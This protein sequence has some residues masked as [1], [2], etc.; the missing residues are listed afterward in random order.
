MAGIFHRE[1]GFFI[2]DPETA[3]F[4]ADYAADGAARRA[5]LQDFI[6]SA[7][8]WRKIFAADGDGESREA[9]TT[10]GDREL[11]AAAAETFAE[12]LRKRS[13]KPSPVA[14]V[15]LDTRFTGPGI[16][17]VMIRVFLLRGI[18]V[19]YLFIVPAPEIMAW[20]KSSRDIDGFAYVSASHNPVGH[21]GLK[22]GLK[23]GVLGGKDAEELIRDFRLLA[24]DDRRMDGTVRELRQDG[25][26]HSRIREEVRRVYGE[27]GPWKKESGSAYG[28]FVRVVASDLSRPGDRQVFFDRLS[29]EIGRRGC[30]IVID[31]NGGAR[32]LSV[33][34]PLLEGLGVRVRIVNGGARDIAHAIVPEGESLETC[35]RELELARERDPSFVFGY[36]PDNDGDRGNLVFFDEASGRAR[37]LE[38]Q[39]VFALACAA[40]L[41]YLAARRSGDTGAEKI[42]VVVNDPTSLRIDRIAAAL[43]AEVRR[44]EVGE[45]NVVALAAELRRDGYTVRILG[46]GSNG[47]NITHPSEVRDPLSTVFAVLKLLHLPEPY[48]ILCRAVGRPDLA[49][50]E[51][52]IGKILGMLPAFRTLGASDPAAILKIRSGDHMALKARYEEIFLREWDRRRR[53]LES[54]FGITSWEEL[55]HEGTV[56]R[57][58][59]GP[60]SRT[61]NGRGGLT[62]LLKGPSGESRGFL[63]M[64]GSGTEPVFRIL[65][66]L[67]GGDGDLLAELAAWQRSMVLE[68]DREG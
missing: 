47:G 53:D 18:R 30:G 59:T 1:T 5:A 8:G 62:I 4:P 15:G 63:W 50:S 38:A 31:M 34:R 10:P 55:N 12:F 58:G 11:C 32:V 65:A 37:P 68:A 16:A 13:G 29:R 6:L 54:R 40:E 43:G 67:E 57:S 22:F 24:G 20:V 52:T 2:G 41:S 35:R 64:R 60:A 27:T 36:T 17:D 26:G 9:A 51:P 56:C 48:E 45:A 14:A 19:R 42:A 21:N 46:E 44:A 3:P 39:E 49:A 66:D 33:D 25:D 28:E 7:S 61:G 23:G